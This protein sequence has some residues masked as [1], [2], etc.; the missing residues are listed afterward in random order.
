VFKIAVLDRFQQNHELLES[1]FEKFQEFQKKR[2]FVEKV[3]EEKYQ[4]GFFKDIFENALGYTLESSSPENGNLLPEEK[5]ETDGKKADG[6]IKVSNSIVGIVELKDFKTKNLSLVEEQAFNYHNSHSNSKY[7][8]I[9]NFS[10]LRFYIDKKTEFIS[11]KL[12]EMNFEEFKRF[13]AI[14]SFES[15]LENLPMKFREETTN[16]EREISEKFYKDF[17]EVRLDLYSELVSE[18]ETKLEALNLS[19]KILDR[20]VFIFFGESRGLLKFSKNYI[21]ETWKSD[22]HES[23]LWEILKIIFQKVD[24]G[25]KIPKTYAYNGG[26]FSFDKKLDS[27]QISDE[28][29]QKVL[30]LGSYDFSTE[31]DVNILG[32]IFENSL[33]DLQKFAENDFKSLRKRD[34]VFYTPQFITKY[35]VENTVGELCRKKWAEIVKNETEKELLDYR[36]FLESLRILDPAVG[37]GAFLN[38]ALDFLVR[39]HEKLREKLLPF[40]DL[41]LGYE[42]DKEILENN[43]F[44]VDINRSAIE[45]AKLSLWIKTAKPNRKLSNLNENLRVANSLLEMPFEEKSFDIVLGNPPYFNI[46]TFGAKSE[47]VE[48]IKNRYSEIWQDKSDI[49]FYFIALS[50]KMSKNR[51]GFIISNAFLFSDKAQKLRNF[52]LENSKIA[53]IVNFEKYEVFED[54]SITTS[55]VI[56]DEKAEK[57]LALNFKDKKYSPEKIVSKMGNVQNF[58]EIELAKNS[59]FALV[60]KRVREVNRKID[61]NHK[62][63]SELFKIGKGMETAGNKVFVFKDFPNQF[64]KEFIKNRVSGENIEKYFLKKEKEYLLYFEEVENFEDLPNSIQNHLSENREFL[65]NRATVKNEGRIWWKYSRPMHKDFYKFDKIWCSYRA[66]ENIFAFD[67]S[68]NSI[69]LTNT[70]VIFDTNEKLSLKYLI[71]LLNSKLLNF[72]YKSIGKQTGNGIFEYF[73]NGVGKLPIPQISPKEQQPIIDLVD[74]LINLKSQISKYK[75]HFDKLSAVEKIEISEEIEKAEN[76]ISEIEKELDKIVYKLYDLNEDEILIVES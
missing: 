27:L 26:L 29:L 48:K 23:S 52:I 2:K 71:A 24:V 13:H 35:I 65:E 36:K 73:P 28:T 12:F 69:G 63:F 47:I 76:R 56:F 9:S 61:S 18:S 14:L 45:V 55:I 68:N 46:Q 34:G 10:E 5:N 7:I 54:A 19:Q 62:K 8:I 21:L 40:G 64:P 66:K 59:V 30:N 20:I 67:N 16:F 44:G 33:D 25:G 37:S 60:D 43:L 70:T 42:F 51:V 6:V 4:E 22:V 38:E 17:S 31:L 15:I 11:F 72:R 58:F 57:S 3:K 32:H 1:R 53:K 50:L 74:E 39:E 41:T 49:L 75:K